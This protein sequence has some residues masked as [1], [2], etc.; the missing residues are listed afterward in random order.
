MRQ[1]WNALRDAK[2]TEIY[3]G[4]SEIQ[5]LVIARGET[6]L[7]RGRPRFVTRHRS[8][9]IHISRVIVLLESWCIRWRSTAS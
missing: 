5:R 7:R 4:T 2:I 1:R 9:P 6:G 8:R 3:E